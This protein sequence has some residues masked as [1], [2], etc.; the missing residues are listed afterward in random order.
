MC[1][2]PKVYEDRKVIAR[3]AHRCC[4]CY[5][6]IA[7]GEPY[8]LF[9]GLWDSWGSY[10]TCP[11][12]QRLRGYFT[13]LGDMYEPKAFGEL[14]EDISESRASCPEIVDY[15]LRNRMRRGQARHSW[16]E[17]AELDAR[18]KIE[19]HPDIDETHRNELVDTIVAWLCASTDQPNW[20]NDRKPC[21]D[22][23]ES[24]R[25]ELKTGKAH[26]AC[27]LKPTT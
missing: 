15:Y 12:C 23:V 20:P 22:A 21:L 9:R 11:E 8:W 3:K 13:R 7:K 1:D 25:L 27:H 24:L 16:L 5:G 14:F 10:K 19:V 18:S 2:A 6:T 4:E 26:C 17:M